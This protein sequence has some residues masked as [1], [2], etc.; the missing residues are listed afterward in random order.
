MTKVILHLKT[1]TKQKTIVLEVYVFTND[2]FIQLMI[3]PKQMVYLW[4]IPLQIVYD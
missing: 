2:H 3:L 1:K 4:K